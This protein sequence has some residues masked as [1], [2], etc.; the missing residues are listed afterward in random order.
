[1]SGLNNSVQRTGRLA[2][3]GQ[4]MAIFALIAVMLFAVTGLAV[5]AGLSYLSYNGAERAAAAG[6]LAGVPYM[7]GGFGGSGCASGTADAAACA[8]TARDG[9]PNGGSISGHPVTVV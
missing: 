8:A 9:Y 4:V 1:M 3:K 5:D 2:G 6:A 7:P